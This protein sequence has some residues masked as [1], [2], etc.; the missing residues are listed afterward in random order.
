MKGI[1]NILI[2]SFVIMGVIFI[3]NNSCKKDE[4]KN[5]TV[6]DID[7]NVYHTVT[8][9]TQVWMVEN[10]NVTHYRNGDS[11]P[12]VTNSSA[13]SGLTKGAY[14]DYENI[15]SNSKV[16][17]KLYNY[18]SILDSRKICPIGWHVATNDE[19]TILID[20]LGGDN[21][22][23]GKLKETGITHWNSPN[24]G[25]NNDMGYTALPGGRRD[26]NGAFSEIG[27]RGTWS[28]LTNHGSDIIFLIMFNNGSS[29][30]RFIS[31]DKRAGNSVRCVRD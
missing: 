31:S 28:S 3:T 21:V 27:S 4:D 8:I 19:W 6:T 1:C 11:I 2:F 23:G 9:G 7:G 5:N 24:I 17:G 29:I 20:F 25:I 13:W 16:Y 30:Y 18:Y 10:L 12:N 15:Q 14:C 26:I 22:A